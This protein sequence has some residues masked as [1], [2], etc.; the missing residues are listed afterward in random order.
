MNFTENDTRDLITLNLI[1]LANPDL[2]KIKLPFFDVDGHYITKRERNACGVVSIKLKDPIFD[3][4]DPLDDSKKLPQLMDDFF[5]K[6]ETKQIPYINENIE[7][8]KLFSIT[9]EAPTLNPQLKYLN[10]PLIY[11]SNHE[12]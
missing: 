7:M 6:P 3:I 8:R 11:L 1:P 2:G 9:M 10:L 12:T 4:E 5:A